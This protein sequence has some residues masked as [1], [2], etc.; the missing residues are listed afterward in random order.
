MVALVSGLGPRGRRRAWPWDVVGEG[1]FFN[2]CFSY[3]ALVEVSCSGYE[4]GMGSVVFVRS[5][6][7]VPSVKARAREGPDL[8]TSTIC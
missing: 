2:G 8:C 5:G 4:S 6:R 1:A 7:H 3:A